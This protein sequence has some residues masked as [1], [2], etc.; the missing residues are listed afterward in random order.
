MQVTL[1]V[2]VDEDVEMKQTTWRVISKSGSSRL[3]HSEYTTLEY[4]TVIKTTGIMP[5]TK[6]QVRL[7]AMGSQSLGHDSKQNSVALSK[8]TVRKRGMLRIAAQIHEAGIKIWK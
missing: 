7:Y 1:K 2:L 3:S 4:K 5:A 6:N 8:Y